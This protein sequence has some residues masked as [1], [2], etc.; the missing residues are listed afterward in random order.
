M[1]LMALL[2]GCLSRMFCEDKSQLCSTPRELTTH[3]GLEIAVDD[4]VM[5]K[6]REGAEDL[7]R[8][9]TDEGGGEAGEAIGL[10]ELVEV[11]A[12]QL[13][14]DAQVTAEGEG[15]DHSNNKVLLVRVLHAKV[16]VHARCRKRHQLTH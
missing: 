16:S 15:L 6:E 7:A 11:D 12:E 10:D 3:L 5:A 1:T 14:D 8:E 4:S 13:G 2:A 9:A